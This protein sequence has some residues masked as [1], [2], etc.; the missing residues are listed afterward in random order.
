MALPTITFNRGTSGL[1][2]PLQGEDH[3]SGMIFYISNAN[4][5]AGFSTSVREKTFFSLQ[6]AENEGILDTNINETKATASIQITAIGSNGDTIEVKVLE[7]A[8]LNLTK[9]VSL[10]TY[11]KTASENN[12]TNVATA[13]TAVINAGTLTHGYTASH[14]SDTVTITARPGLGVFLNSGTPLS[15]VIVGGITRTLTQFSGGVASDIDQ[16]HYHISEYFRIQPQGILHVGIYAPEVG[17]YTFSNVPTLFNYASGKLRQ[18][19]VYV[20]GDTLDAALVT[21]LDARM[22]AQAA[23]MR[24]ASAVLTADFAG[25]ALSALPSLSA[26]S[27]YRVSVDIAQDIGGKGYKLYK[28]LGKTVGTLGALLGNISLAKVSESIAWVGKF[29]VSNGT[30]LETVGFGNGVLFR[31]QAVSLL[32]QLDSYKYV[33][34]RKYENKSGSYWSD[35]ETA[36]S[37]TSDFSQIENVRTVDKAIRGIYAN[38]LDLLNSPL[39]VNSDGTLTEDTISVFQE[40]ASLQL[41]EMGRN[42]EL[43]AYTININPAQNVLSTSKIVI[44]VTIV[45]IGV[46]REIVFNV[47]LSTT[48]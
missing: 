33:F 7:Y 45:P 31:D 8:E 12:A 35:S 6:D 40:K 18:I 32:D 38:T 14:S 37:T 1:G 27:D 43:S 47:N 48:A 34:L 22:M 26:N 13:L 44:S 19:G 15:T 21:S 28:A 23:L 36:I 10:G 42:N 39:E 9:S 24:P 17:S 30:E 3:I 29:D 2:R 25:T 4:L 41:D 46:A 11:T 5:P 16:L 20:T